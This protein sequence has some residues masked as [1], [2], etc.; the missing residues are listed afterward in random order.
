MGGEY[1]GER[2]TDFGADEMSLEA[3]KVAGLVLHFRTP[4]S[5]LSCICSLF[6]EGVRS[7]VL[8]DNSEDG[9]VS[10]AE[11]GIGFDHLAEAGADVQVLISDKNLGFAKGVNTGLIYAIRNGAGAVLLINSD[12]QLEG[13][14]LASM[15]KSLEN[16]SVA[17]P[18]ARRATGAVTT[19]LFG[20]YQRALALVLRS[21]WPGCLT[22]PTGCCLL[23]RTSA[24]SLPLFDEQFFF[25]GEDVLLGLEFQS[26]GLNVVECADAT[27]IHAGSGSARNGSFFYEYHMNRGHWLLARKLAPNRFLWAGYVACRCLSLPLRAV[28]RSLRFRSIT[29]WRALVVATLDV[30]RNRCRTFTPAAS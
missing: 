12:A 16:A 23:L 25:Y 13:G 10:L 24:A 5:T 17:V 14:A 18:R 19:S 3:G 11:M 26:K 15:I 6:A 8:V 9:G 30:A 22:Y 28:I 2:R 1:S 4:E 7:F 20:N 27:I 29:P 21:P